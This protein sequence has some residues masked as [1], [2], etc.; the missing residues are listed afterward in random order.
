MKEKFMKEK[1]VKEKLQKEKSMFNTK[2]QKIM[3]INNT[4]Y[5]NELISKIKEASLSIRH[6]DFRRN[7]KISKKFD[8]FYFKNLFRSSDSKISANRL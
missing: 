6:C 7:K 8:F 4:I 1:F 3:N 5:H 2:I